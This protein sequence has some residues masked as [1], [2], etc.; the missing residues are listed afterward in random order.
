MM[1]ATPVRVKTEVSVATSS[2]RPRCTRPPFPEYS[3]SL[4]SRT[5][6]QSRSPGE[7]FLSG[8]VI[9]GRTRAGRTLAY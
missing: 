7:Q 5:I 3:P 6:T 8:A 1:R 4:F 2:G 9:P